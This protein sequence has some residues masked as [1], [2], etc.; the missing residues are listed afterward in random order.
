VENELRE[1]LKN[2]MI[3]KWLLYQVRY[4]TTYKFPV[5]DVTEL[6]EPGEE[7]LDYL[8][9]ALL[10]AHG[11]PQQ[12]RDQYNILLEDAEDNSL[13]ILKKYLESRV[14]PAK[15][16]F[17][18]IARTGNF[19]EVLASLLLVEFED[20]WFPIY[21]LRFREKKDWAMR[22]TDLCLIKQSDGAKPLV[23]YGEVKTISGARN[24]DIAIEGHASLVLGEAKDALSDPEVLHFIS[25]ILY[26]THRYAERDFISRIQLGKIEYD[27]RHDLFIIHSRERWTDE[28]LDRLQAYPLDS[29]LVNFSLKVVLVAQLKKLI[30]AAYGQSTVVTKALINTMNKQ[31]YLDTI[32]LTLASLAKDAQ[33][34]R[35]LAQVQARSIQEELSSTQY[36]PNYTFTLEDIWRKCEYIFSNSSLLL[37]EEEAAGDPE[38]RKIVFGSLRTVAQS[39]EFLSK[40]AKEEEVE[41][42]LINSAICYHL[43]GYHANAQCLAKLLQQKY[44][45]EYKTGGKSPDRNNTLTWF[46]RQ[47]LVFFLR[48][49]ITNLRK[50][51]EQAIAFVRT[52]Q[53][54]L[55]VNTEEE[56]VIL[57]ISDLYGHLFFQKALFNFT[58][59]CIHGTQEQLSLAQ[60]NILKCYSY[61][62]HTR[63]TVEPR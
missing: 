6:I 30:D 55:V 28:I 34:Q 3:K 10:L 7:L 42:L 53:E 36:I 19:G 35:E 46:F 48:R 51:T 25:T 58:E 15:E 49:D 4:P 61:F 20:F 16:V 26:E 18:G 8:A 54:A 13:D 29:R 22:L 2:N 41:I 37:R 52:T 1:G 38:Q 17:H 31:E 21:K 43:A 32:H 5:H 62:Q 33:F 45:S 12:I 27:K 57:N 39:F 47:A 23:C 11:N 59:Y 60:R 56:D 50:V 44:R 24:K 40:F 14:F 63:D 9:L